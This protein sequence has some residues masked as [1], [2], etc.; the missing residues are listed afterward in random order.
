M[1]ISG[2]DKMIISGIAAF[3]TLALY[4]VFFGRRHMD[5]RSKLS[6]DLDQVSTNNDKCNVCS[7]KLTTLYNGKTITLARHRI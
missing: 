6:N 5:E 1:T 3:G 4:Y 7:I 2:R